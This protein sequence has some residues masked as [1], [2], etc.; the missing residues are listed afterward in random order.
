MEVKD[1][2][3]TVVTRAGK[4]TSPNLINLA[5][6]ATPRF[7]PDMT[8][9]GET[10]SPA[11]THHHDDEDPLNKNK[12]QV[13]DDDDITGGGATE[14]QPTPEVPS[15]AGRGFT[16]VGSTNYERAEGG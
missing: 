15:T 9:E 2:A 5:A 12:Q 16:H 3:G 1:K 11:E 4:S 13:H 7:S 6:G 10:K 8:D 14:P